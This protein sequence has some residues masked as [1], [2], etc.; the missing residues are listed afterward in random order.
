MSRTAVE[1]STTERIVA[2][3]AE[4]FAERGVDSTSLEQVAERA[5]VH[6]ATLHRHLPGGRDELVAA[7]VQ[8]EAE[9][10]GTAVME[11]LAVAPTAR[12]GLTDA[13]T[14]AVVTARQNQVIAALIPAPGARDAVFGPGAARLVRVTR[15]AWQVAAAVARREGEP[16]RTDLDPDRVVGHLIRVLV[17]LVTE[18]AGLE[19]E[20]EVRTYI[21]D[22]VTPAFFTAPARGD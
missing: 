11:A 20:D 3:A 15:E 16:L 17:S 22:M 6:R 2:A 12:T 5:Q 9:W 8:R 1:P 13:L 19:T 18:P 14:V 10:M 4:C 7:V 21:A